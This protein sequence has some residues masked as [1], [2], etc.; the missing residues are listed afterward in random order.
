MHN[1]DIIALGFTAKE[2]VDFLQTDKAKDAKKSLNYFDGQQEEEVVK[3]LNKP[4]SGRVDWKNNGLMPRFRNVTKMVVEKSG[5]LFKDKFPVAELYN[6]NSVA[7]NQAV[8]SI[9]NEQLARIETVEYL[10]NFDQLN[11]LLKT[12]IMLVQ[13]DAQT[14]SVILDYLHRANCE[15]VLD[16]SRNVIGMIH[17]THDNRYAVWTLDEI[18]E[19]RVEGRKIIASSPVVNTYG[20]I[21]IAAFYDT[22]TPRTGF[23]S[24]QDKSLV[25]FNEI[26]NL[27]YTDAEK[28]LLWSKMSTPV[29]NLRP[30]GGSGPVGMRKK[31]GGVLPRMV[32]D[33][34]AGLLGGPGNAVVLDSQGVENPFFRYESPNVDLKAQEEVVKGWIT[35]IASDWSVRIDVAGQQQGRAQ[36]GFQLVVEEL[37]NIDLRKQRQRMFESGFKRFYKVFARVYNVGTGT[38]TFPEDAELFVKFGDPVLPVELTVQTN[39]W[40]Q[41]IGS[42]LA[43]EIDALMDIYGLTE[44]EAEEK[45]M[46]TI[47]F[48]KRKQE[49]LGPPPE[50]AVQ[51]TEEDEPADEDSNEE[52]TEDK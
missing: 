22:A 6:K 7:V 42:G 38:N 52:I 46:K 28:S 47:A 12:L 18:I 30:V 13:W 36:S 37:D 35:G 1:N 29:T 15:V 10:T 20:L 26:V 14:E 19:I 31:P 34:R 25:N 51:P 3:A 21:P 33:E 5:M 16:E 27:H 49:L 9:L 8:T 23:W 45:F 39:V 4:S 2:W 40:Q 17:K 24:E 48:N 11:R 44:E 41:R 32:H 50:P 43:T